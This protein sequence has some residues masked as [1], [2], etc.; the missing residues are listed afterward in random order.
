M[1]FVDVSILRPFCVKTFVTKLALL[2]LIG[3]VYLDVIL[4]LH[5]GF[6]TLSTC[7]T[8]EFFLLKVDPTPMHIEST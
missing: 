8:V 4:Q 7:D 5:Q 6:E 2:L 1:D 3:L